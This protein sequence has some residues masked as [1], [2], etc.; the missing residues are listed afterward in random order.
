MFSA[1]IWDDRE[2]KKLMKTDG[3]Q[4]LEVDQ[5]DYVLKMCDKY[6]HAP[7]KKPTRYLTNEAVEEDIDTFNSCSTGEQRSR[8]LPDVCAVLERIVRQQVLNVVEN[9]VRREAVRR[10][11]ST[12]PRMRCAERA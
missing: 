9:E 11:N 1:S 3:V 4:V 8:I 12:S 2:V 6:K 10:K 7:T 5:C